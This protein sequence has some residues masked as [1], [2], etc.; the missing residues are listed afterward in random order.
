MKRFH[1]LSVLLILTSCGNTVKTK[2]FFISN[3]GI[4]C[5]TI[6]PYSKDLKDCSYGTDS[7]KRFEVLNATNVI[8]VER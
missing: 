3:T 1:L 8:I 6:M 2:Y 5:R 4:Y 7:T